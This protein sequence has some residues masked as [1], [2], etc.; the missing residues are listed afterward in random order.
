MQ[1]KRIRPVRRPSSKNSAQ[2]VLIPS[3]MHLQ[4]IAPPLMQPCH[5][6]NV[7]IHLDSFQ[8]LGDFG[9][10][11]DPH[12]RRSFIPLSR[13]TAS[14]LKTRSHHPDRPQ[15]IIDL[16]R[17]PINSPFKLSATRRLGQTRAPLA[18]AHAAKPLILC[19]PKKGGPSNAL[20]AAKSHAPRTKRTNPPSREG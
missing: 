8:P 2:H 16:P 3:R 19:A 5:H 20:R 17:H 14:F 12:V 7:R 11:L 4:N 10:N 13:R 1:P 15:T 9:S 18:F 6:E